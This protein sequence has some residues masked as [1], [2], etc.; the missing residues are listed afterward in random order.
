MVVSS[1]AFHLPAQVISIK[2]DGTNFLAWSAQLLPIF[3][4]YGL[5]EIVDCSDPCP[6]KFS[7]D[8]LKAQG[9]L[10]SA[11]V[12]WQYKDQTILGWIVSS[13]SPFIVYTIYGL[14]TSR[15]AW[16]ALG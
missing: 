4:S 13:L 5:M 6:P 7:N 2:L 11:Y 3:R 8:E 1:A 10:N 16:Q 15:L 12:V 9:V 14:E